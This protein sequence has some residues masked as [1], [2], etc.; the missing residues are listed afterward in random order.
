MFRSKP[1]QD[2]CS[3]H[4]W[5]LS[6][7]PKWPDEGKWSETRAAGYERHH[8]LLDR[9]ATGEV[10]RGYLLLAGQRLELETPSCH[11]RG[12]T[13]IIIDF[14]ANCDSGDSVITIPSTS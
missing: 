6:S 8:A 7:E 13:I 3:A 9:A 14:T 4:F 1:R 5:C 11:L 2:I 12:T 10:V